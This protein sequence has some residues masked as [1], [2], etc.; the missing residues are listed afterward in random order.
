MRV[1]TCLFLL[2]IE[3]AGGLQRLCS[4]LISVLAMTSD[5]KNDCINYRMMGSKE[6]IGDWGH[7]YVR[8]VDSSIF[9][10]LR[11]LGVEKEDGSALK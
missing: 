2:W 9:L 7:E 8:Y 4:D 1:G 5:E 10:L 3:N 6:P 11:H